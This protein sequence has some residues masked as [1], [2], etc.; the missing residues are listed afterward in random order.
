MRLA[1]ELTPMAPALARRPMRAGAAHRKLTCQS[2]HG[3][4]RY[5]TRAAAVDACLQCHADEHSVRYAESPHARAWD[6]EQLGE[7]PAGSGVSCATCHLPRRS[8][9]AATTA[10]GGGPTIAVE[11]NQ[12]DNL[13]P[14]EKMI[15]SVCAP[16]HGLA[17]SIDAL[18]DRDLIDSNFARRPDRHIPSIEMVR[19]T[20]TAD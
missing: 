13:R 9:R 3:A 7:G 16:C 14:N 20:G 6:R 18:A 19:G 11:H 8:T 12:N 5:D 1:H 2:C 4:H 10:S 15:R 17:F